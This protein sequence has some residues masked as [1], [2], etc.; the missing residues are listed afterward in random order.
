MFKESYSSVH[1]QSSIVLDFYQIVQ[2]VKLH[3]VA[4]TELLV[5]AQP[6]VDSS[7]PVRWY[8]VRRRVPGG[9][10]EGVYPTIVSVALA[11]GR[12]S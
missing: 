8:R 7:I 12:D 11:M 3:T 10:K 9:G 6:R 4:K 1:P 5:I 2:F